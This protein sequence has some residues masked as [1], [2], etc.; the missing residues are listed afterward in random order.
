MRHART[1]KKG[2]GNKK[3][4]RAPSRPDRSPLDHATLLIDTI[5]TIAGSDSFPTAADPAPSNRLR[6]AI[7]DHDTPYLF[8]W[9][10]EAFSFQ[11][12]SDAA[13]TAYMNRH[14]RLRWSDVEEALARPRSCP[15]LLAHWTFQRCGYEK[16]ACAC[17]E[18]RHFGRCPLPRFDLR[19][20]RINV[21]GFSLFLFIRDVAEGDLVRWI[22]RRLA[23]ARVGSPAG[24][25]ARMQ[26]ALIEPFEEVFSAGRKIL[27]MA[28][29]DLLMAAPRAKPY[30]HE[31]GASMV[32]VDTLV[33]SFMHRS[34]I[35]R[36]FGT[37]HAYG[38]GCYGEGG[39]AEVILRAS[40]RINARQCNAGYPARFPRWVQHA[41]WRY[42]AAQ[43]I[44]VC[45]GNP[46]DDAKRCRNTGCL[47]FPECDRVALTKPEPTRR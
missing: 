7:A 15:K 38:A 47:L 26:E 31:T 27:N 5:C 18:P 33:H 30:W 10:V 22:D 45:N 37:E 14:G 3:R 46:I 19:N 29:A 8:E 9:L 36:R 32:S 28:L 42:C 25:P 17:A 44:D 1:K 24:R 43:E 40:W 16:T 4:P 20:G 35:L 23:M 39:C 41:A 2:P 12:V 21:M 13:A 34:G 11:G 6:S